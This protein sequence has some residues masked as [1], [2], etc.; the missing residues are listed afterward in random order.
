MNEKP[1]TMICPECGVWRT[2]D[3]EV[4]Y[5][6][7]CGGGRLLHAC[8]RCGKEFDQISGRYHNTCGERLVGRRPAPGT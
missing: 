2:L 5:C 1:K 7:D 3:K 6:L 8:P 4:A